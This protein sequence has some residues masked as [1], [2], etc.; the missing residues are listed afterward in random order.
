[1]KCRDS[2]EDAYFPCG[3]ALLNLQLR[4]VWKEHNLSIQVASGCMV[5]LLTLYTAA[6]FLGYLGGSNAPKNINNN[7]SNN[8]ADASTE[9]QE[10]VES[11]QSP[12]TLLSVAATSTTTTTTSTPSS[13][14][15][16]ERDPATLESPS[17]SGSSS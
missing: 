5:C 15:G 13:A 8:N 16:V 14:Q 2:S 3:L 1:M 11:N 10:D 12:T 7:N 17:R 4:Q 6:T 9:Q